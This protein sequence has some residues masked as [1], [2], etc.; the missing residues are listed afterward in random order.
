METIHYKDAGDV[1][2]KEIRTSEYGRVKQLEAEY[3]N[4]GAKTHV[5]LYDPCNGIWALTVTGA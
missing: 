5:A 3:K 1:W 4:R 2:H